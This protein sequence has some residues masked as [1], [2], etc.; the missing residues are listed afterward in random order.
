VQLVRWMRFSFLTS[1][2]TSKRKKRKLILRQKSTLSCPL[3]MDDFLTHRLYIS[4]SQW[5]PLHV[6]FLCCLL[7]FLQTP[8]FSLLLILIFVV[9]EYPPH[10]HTHTHTHTH[11]HPHTH[12]HT[13]TQR[14]E[15]CF[16]VV[17]SGGRIS[18]AR[19][20]THTLSLSSPD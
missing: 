17:V 7:L 16:Y 20:H 3:S 15:S 11:T 12:T 5:I 18:H 9:D 6:N 19:S 13:H 10:L 8:L 4:L 14:T 1:K 2:K